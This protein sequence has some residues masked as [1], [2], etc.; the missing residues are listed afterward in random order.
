MDWAV[1]RRPVMT[2][3]MSRALAQ[4][5]T[6]HSR[7]VGHAAALLRPARRGP[8]NTNL[9]GSEVDRIR[10]HRLG[11]RTSLIRPV[12]LAGSFHHEAGPLPFSRRSAGSPACAVFASSIAQSCGHSALA[13][14]PPDVPPARRIPTARATLADRK[15]ARRSG[16]MADKRD[17][18]K[19]AVVDMDMP[20][21]A[22]AGTRPLSALVLSGGM[23]LGAFEAGAYAALE[24][25]GKQAPDIVVGASAGAVNAA[26]IAGNPPGAR[27]EPLRRFWDMMATNPTPAATFL[28]G[29]PPPVGAW[30]AAYN[31][32][33]AMQ[34]LLLGHPAC[35]AR[36]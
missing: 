12:A 16:L 33:S 4:T 22:Q 21:L 25:A 5:A 24:D 2:L 28:F 15:R 30:R 23:A 20:N 17:G 31:E 19:G 35:S 9:A 7:R 18:R 14:N 8:G 10:L 13:I 34:T 3:F 11:L 29:P 36:G 27:T 32:A 26:I 1:A 6:V